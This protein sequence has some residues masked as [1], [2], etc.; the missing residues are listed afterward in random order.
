MLSA[1]KILQIDRLIHEGGLSQRA[2]ALRLG[3]SRGTVANIAHG[4][5]RVECPRHPPQQDQPARSLVATRCRG[6]GGM[7]Y[8]PCLLCRARDYRRR[9]RLR[10]A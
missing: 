9:C 2:I 5:L 6:C 1:A 8:A 4:R 10:V 3:V 7:M